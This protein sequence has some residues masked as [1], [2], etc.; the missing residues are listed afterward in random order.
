MPVERIMWAVVNK[1][2]HPIYIPCDSPDEGKSKILEPENPL[3]IEYT[4]PQYTQKEFCDPTAHTHTYFIKF[5]S[6]NDDD[7]L[8]GHLATV[9]IQG[10]GFFKS[11][12][13][14]C[15]IVYAYLPLSRNEEP[16][17]SCRIHNV[18]EYPALNSDMTM[19]HDI[20]FDYESLTFDFKHIVASNL[21]DLRKIID[22]CLAQSMDKL[23]GI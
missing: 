15:A 9:A 5:H 14:N 1:T 22:T 21:S 12:Y 20:I 7:E 13:I 8:Y 18:L 2:N 10:Y 11:P 4:K 6:L 17:V 19:W 3:Y 16:T 23:G